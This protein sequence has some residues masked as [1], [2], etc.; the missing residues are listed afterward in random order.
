M[1]LIIIFGNSCQYKE[2]KKIYVICKKEIQ[3]DKDFYSHMVF[4]DFVDLVYDND[5]LNLNMIG[6]P[7]GLTEE[8][9]KEWLKRYLRKLINNG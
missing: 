9:E 1:F 6:C 2:F 3:E 4:D 5:I 7:D 8:Q